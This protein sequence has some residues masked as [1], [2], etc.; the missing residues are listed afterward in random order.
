MVTALAGALFMALYIRTRSLPAL[1]L[2]HWIV[3]VVA[4]ADWVPAGLF[5]LL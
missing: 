2:A 4:F 5:R 1:V 3:D